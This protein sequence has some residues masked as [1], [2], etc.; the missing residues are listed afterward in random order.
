M[1][2]ILFKFPYIETFLKTVLVWFAY[3]MQLLITYVEKLKRCKHFCAAQVDGSIQDID[4]IDTESISVWIYT[5]L[6]KS[7]L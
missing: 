2:K 7:K 6:V 3:T 1:H 4:N 5:S